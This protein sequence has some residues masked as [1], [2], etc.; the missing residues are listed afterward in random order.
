MYGNK[1]TPSA[2]VSNEKIKL[3]T[4]LHSYSYRKSQLRAVTVHLG[5]KHCGKKQELAII[6]DEETPRCAP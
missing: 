1:M 3:I 5:R 4:K 6:S 2:A